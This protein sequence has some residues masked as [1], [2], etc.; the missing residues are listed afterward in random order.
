M[1]FLIVA[2]VLILSVGYLY[3]TETDRGPWSDWC[4]CNYEHHGLFWFCSMMLFTI[5][6]ICSGIGLVAMAIVTLA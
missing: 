5:A 1:E 4:H 2:A 6:A 3:M